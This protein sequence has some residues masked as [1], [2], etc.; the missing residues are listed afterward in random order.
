MKK[1]YTV[2]TAAILLFF[3]ANSQHFTRNVDY[4][5]NNVQIEHNSAEQMKIVGSPVR[6][7]ITLQISNP[8]S[9]KYELSLYTSTGRK[10]STELY[11]HPAGVSTKTMYTSNLERGIYFLVATSEYGRRSIEVLIQ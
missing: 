1:I 3:S 8:V 4:A 11:N 6:N 2:V 5:D 7:I 9:T 10:V